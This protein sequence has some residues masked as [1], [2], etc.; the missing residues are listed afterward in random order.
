M[1]DKLLKL[2][3]KL[4]KRLSKAEQKLIKFFTVAMIS[5]FVLLM[6]VMKLYTDISREQLQ[7]AEYTDE[8]NRLIE[9]GRDSLIDS[10]E[11]IADVITEIE[12]QDID[13]HMKLIEIYKQ[14]K[15]FHKIL[16]H[17]ERIEPFNSDDLEFLTIA[18]K[19]FYAS[20]KPHEA[21]RYLQD[22]HALNPG[23]ADIA[24]ELYLAEF[25]TGKI[26]E[27]I[28]KLEKLKETNPGSPKLAT[29]LG[30]VKAELDPNN[31]EAEDHFKE[32]IR[33]DP[34]Y[35][36]SWYQY[37]RMKMNQGNYGEARD[38][39]KQSV[40]LDPLNPKFNA[41]LGMAYYYLRKDK[42]AEYSYRTALAINDQDYNTHYNL[43]E[44]Y[45]SWSDDGDKVKKVRTNIA[46]ALA[47]YLE[48]LEL[49][50]EHL[51]AHYKVGLIMNGNGQHKEAIKH[52]S[53]TIEKL[54]SHV[55]ALM[56]LALAY[57]RLNKIDQAKIYYTMAYE[58]DPF[59]RIIL[60]KYKEFSL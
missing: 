7:P 37:G 60:Q 26:D 52:L 32:A 56:Q 5:I 10:L 2:H 1:L 45:M 42:K 38:R 36:L 3:L 39:I 28:N 50:G 43:G 11:L 33:L 31:N 35:P 21:I 18:G 12:P 22:A 44:L 49:N 46:N 4:W 41:R 58:E 51:H 9:S 8:V 17:I 34:N 25:K 14:A 15:D 24:M 13:A 53:K 19:A 55:S 57:E 40:Q 48:C 6:G 30:T 29:F 27:A 59:N 20:G 16:P 23:D 54:P 47:S